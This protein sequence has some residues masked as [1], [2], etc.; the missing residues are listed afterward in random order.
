[1]E[2][3]GYTAT[4]SFDDEAMIFHGELLGL[5]DVVTFQGSSVKE[6]KQ[7]MAD[8]VDDYLN[9][10]KELVRTPEKPFSGKL[11]VRID[12]DLHRSLAVTAKK[13][14]KSVNSLVAE[15]L[16]TVVAQAG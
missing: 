4:V 2:Y 16:K 1:M 11:L 8:S 9:Y 12:P 3:K 13:A 7:A 10:C 14:G 15:A 5:R 6:L